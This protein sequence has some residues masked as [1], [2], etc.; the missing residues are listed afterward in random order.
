VALSYYL[1]ASGK[2]GP[3]ELRLM[4]F[5]I[6]GS[7]VMK[8][9]A[10]L[11]A[12]SLTIITFP[13]KV[14]A[15]FVLSIDPADLTFNGPGNHAIDIR[16]QFVDDGNPNT[17]SGYTMRFGSSANASS[18]ILPNGVVFISATEGLPVSG[19]QFFSLTANSVAAANFTL[20]GNTIIPLTPTTLFTIN[21]TLGNAA[22]YALGIDFQ[23]AQRGGLLGTEVGGEFF[24]PNSPTTDLAFTLTAVP[25]PSSFVIIACFTGIGVYRI[26][27][28]RDGGL[29]AS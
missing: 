24:N 29:T 9:F 7:D 21:A 15:A 1:V 25:E 8:F 5:L 6:L 28:R 16:I 22:S 10:F 19:G 2:T 23:N 11:A 14:D 20:P 13:T 17:L 3:D 12:V 26:L 4:P 18:S 27:R